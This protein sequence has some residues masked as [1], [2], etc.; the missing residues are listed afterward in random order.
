MSE[1]FYQFGVHGI[2]HAQTQ[3]VLRFQLDQQ[4]KNIYEIKELLI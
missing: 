4:T 3:H 2:I 1:P